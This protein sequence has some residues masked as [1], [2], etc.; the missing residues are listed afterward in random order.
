MNTTTP[1]PLPDAKPE[2]QPG[3]LSALTLLKQPAAT[4]GAAV[5]RGEETALTVRFTVSAVLCLA[6]F[7]LVL[8]TYAGG[9]QLWAV[10]LKV[11]GGGLFAALLCLPSLIIFG[12]MG[13]M[14]LGL[15]RALLL[16]SGMLAL[17]G[18]MLVG[19]APVVW[20]FSVSTASDNFMGFL[21][22]VIALIAFIIGSRAQWKMAAQLGL[23]QVGGLC[24]WTV[25]FIFVI[26]QLTCTLRPL[27]GQYDRFLHVNEKRFFITHWVDRGK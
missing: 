3:R 8:G 21:A 16:L 23:R 15:R 7:G 25:M 20:L 12:V 2:P 24:L 27:I 1:P 10:P 17:T 11:A 5:A 22:V 4:V 6:V 26:L 18:L 14:D 19:F 9:A 13:G